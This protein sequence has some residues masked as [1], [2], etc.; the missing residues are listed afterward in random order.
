MEVFVNSKPQ[1]VLNKATDE[2][3]KYFIEK[4]LVSSKLGY[5]LCF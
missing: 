5:V 4:E 1:F 2:N 3:L